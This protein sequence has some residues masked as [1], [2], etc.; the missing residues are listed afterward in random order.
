MEHVGL[1]IGDASGVGVSGVYQELFSR[2]LGGG[3]SLNLSSL[4]SFEKTM[5]LRTTIRNYWWHRRLRG[6]VVLRDGAGAVGKDTVRN[7]R[8]S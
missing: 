1:W 4:S 3:V 6:G 7:A 8:S 5:G 2:A